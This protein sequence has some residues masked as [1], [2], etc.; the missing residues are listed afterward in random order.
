MLKFQATPQTASPL[1]TL[2]DA[3]ERAGS[4]H[5]DT[6]LRHGVCDGLVGQNVSAVDV[7]LV[8]DDHVLAQNRHVLH[9]NL[10]EEQDRMES[11]SSRVKGLTKNKE[12]VY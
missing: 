12:L 6:W 2:G 10:E 7:E 4:L 9:P 5:D 3:H 11:Q 1:H 8:A